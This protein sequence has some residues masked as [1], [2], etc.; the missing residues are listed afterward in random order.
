MFY[1]SST[2]HRRKWDCEKSFI[3]ES[4][5]ENTILVGYESIQFIAMDYNHN[6]INPNIIYKKYLS[7]DDIIMEYY[8][9]VSH[10]NYNNIQLSDIM[11]ETTK[12]EQTIEYIMTNDDYDEGNHYI[13]AFVFDTGEDSLYFTSDEEM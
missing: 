9:I 13:I 8:E 2:E 7:I 11:Y 1:N 12:H 10:V 5:N 6:K 3:R 4:N